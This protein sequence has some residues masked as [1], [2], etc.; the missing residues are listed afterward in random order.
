[1][2]EYE[3]VRV[4]DREIELKEREAYA[5]VH[6]VDE[7]RARYDDDDPLGDE[8]GVM[9]VSEVTG[10]RASEVAGAPQGAALQV[11]AGKHTP[12]DEPEPLDVSDVE[13][14]IKAEMGAWYR[15]ASKRKADKRAEFT[16]E[17]VPP[18][19]AAVIRERLLVAD[20]DQEVKAAFAGPFLV[21]AGRVSPSGKDQNGDAKDRWE[22][23]I[24]RL[25]RKRL[26]D[27]MKDVLKILGWPPDFDNL[28]E[29]FWESATGQMITDLRPMIEA[30][31]TDAS[32]TMIESTGV[33][34]DWALVAQDASQW[35]TRYTFDL[36]RGVTETTREALRRKI[37]A[38]VETP[39]MTREQLEESLRPLFGDARASMIAVTETTR[40]YAEG[41][42]ETARRAQEQGF[43]LEPKWHTANDELVCNICGPNEGKLQTEGW[44]VD[45]PPA[46]V[47]CRCWVTHEWVQ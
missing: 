47:N 2:A 31:A 32:Q 18:D 34:V 17:H 37:A 15:Y 28:D 12:V 19:V 27:Q 44:T 33:G 38:F 9:L 45:W 7:V 35:A 5:L 39:G 1:V 26:G 29:A 14:A 46:H 4:V 36:V 40:A 20:S 8:R 41:E 21:K 23:R 6:T 24:L 3:D 11:E 22:R 10:Q 25:M 13:A 42:R 16:C 30:M 43:R